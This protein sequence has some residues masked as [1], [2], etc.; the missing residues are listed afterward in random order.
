MTDYKINAIVI[1]NKEKKKEV[2]V[3]CQVVTQDNLTYYIY[4]SMG[5]PLIFYRKKLKKL[6]NNLF[7]D[8]KYIYYL[9]NKE[10]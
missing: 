10:S 7:E 3:K 6:E 2:L 9:D 1:F 5:N 8:E 4:R